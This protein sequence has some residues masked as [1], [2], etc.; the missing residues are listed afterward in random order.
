MFPGIRLLI[1]AVAAYVV[2]LSCGFGVFAALRV[3]HEPLLPS[4]TAPLQLVPDNV[5]PPTVR[6]GRPSPAS[7]PEIATTVADESAPENE[8]APHD[9]GETQSS[10]RSDAEP[11]ALASGADEKTQAAAQPADPP[12][13]RSTA[14]VAD[15]HSSDAAEPEPTP[16][17][18]EGDDA[19][20]ALG[21]TAA[22]AEGG[23]DKADKSADTAG[24]LAPTTTPN[25]AAL[26]LAPANEAAWQSKQRRSNSTP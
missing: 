19:S 6:S 21:A 11:E 5:A 16:T 8:S 24:E 12:E 7:E 10:A 20:K 3:N 26:E 2:A 14:L 13:A 4:A 9:G 25:V 1:A 23:E 15:D 17:S 22:A 18:A